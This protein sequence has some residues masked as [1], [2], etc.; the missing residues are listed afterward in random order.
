VQFGRGEKALYGMSRVA[1]NEAHIFCQYEGCDP[2]MGVKMD[3]SINVLGEPLEPCGEN[4][5]TGFFRDGKCNTCDEDLGSHTVCIE[6]T[7]EFLDFSQSRGN[8][9]STPM[10]DFDFPGLRPGD[11]W[12]LCAAR[13]LEAYKSGQAP[14]VYVTK[15]H[16]KALEVVPLELLREYAIDLN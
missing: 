1:E 3:N 2:E 6:A 13:W 8:D 12:C 10:P 14:R 15:T 9:L 16:L 11:T 5:L 4:P 7:R